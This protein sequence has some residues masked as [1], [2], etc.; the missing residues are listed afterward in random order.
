MCVC[1]CELLVD[2]LA[3]IRFLLLGQFV[4]SFV[5]YV[6][7]V[8]VLPG[9]SI[10][11]LLH[12]LAIC[13]QV[14][15]CLCFAFFVANN[16]GFVFRKALLQSKHDILLDFFVVVVFVAA[17]AVVRVRCEFLCCPKHHTDTLSKLKSNAFNCWPLLLI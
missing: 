1:L 10:S 16:R 15:L 9:A 13:P 14:F 6:V 8:V 2:I 5:H 4:R 12:V 17:A 11:R 7:V 3:F